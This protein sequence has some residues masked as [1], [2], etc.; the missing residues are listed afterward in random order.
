MQ[1]VIFAFHL[2]SLRRKSSSNFFQFGK[3]VLMRVSCESKEAGNE[4]SKNGRCLYFSDD[5][6]GPDLMFH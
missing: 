4:I 5:P 6:F 1:N 3:Q 2:F